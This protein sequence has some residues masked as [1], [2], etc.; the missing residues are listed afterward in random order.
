MINSSN[1]LSVLN[2]EEG[3][4]AFYEKVFFLTRTLVQRCINSQYA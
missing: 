1:H 3:L 2:Y 4:S